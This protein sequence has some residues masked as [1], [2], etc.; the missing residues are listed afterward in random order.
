MGQLRRS[1]S[2]CTIHV[3]PCAIVFGKR[4]SPLKAIPSPTTA[5]ISRG[6][7][8]FD[9]I[10][11]EDCC[12]PDSV[13]CRETEVSK[14]FLKITITEQI[15]FASQEAAVICSDNLWY[16]SSS[17]WFSCPCPGGIS[18]QNYN[19]TRGAATVVKIEGHWEKFRMLLSVFESV[20]IPAITR[21]ASIFVE[22]ARNCA[23]WKEREVV[24]F[25]DKYDF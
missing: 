6:G 11:V 1:F 25:F 10:L 9:R 17:L 5:I 8:V 7:K 3:L 24:A 23:Y 2:S 4:S 12:G 16:F 21:G 20:A 13:L 19:M 14:G 22:W 15:D 18:W